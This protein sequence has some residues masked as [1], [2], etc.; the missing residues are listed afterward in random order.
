MQSTLAFAPGPEDLDD[1]DLDAAILTFAPPPRDATEAGSD[2][3]EDRA[4]A[5]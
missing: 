2:P 5:P 1:L 4:E 3:A